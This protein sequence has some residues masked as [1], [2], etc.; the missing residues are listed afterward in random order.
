LPLVKE[1]LLKQSDWAALGVD[2]KS[3]DTP[4]QVT[5]A[6]VTYVLGWNNKLVSARNAPKNWDDLLDPKWKGA[7]GIWVNP[8]PF[9]D[10]VL[11]WARLK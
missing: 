4:W 11:C 3:I 2:E 9:A 5:F 10:L 1:G 8:F 7:V 6:T